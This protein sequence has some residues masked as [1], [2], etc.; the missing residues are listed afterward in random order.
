MSRKNHRK[1]YGYENIPDG[2]DIHHINLNDSI[3]DI[4][5]LIAVPKIVHR[6]IHSA[7]N[8]HLD[9]YDEDDEKFLYLWERSPILKRSNILKLI[10]IYKKNESAEKKQIEKKLREEIE[11]LYANTL[12]AYA[13]KQ[14]SKPKVKVTLSE[15]RKKEI[16]DYAINRNK[17]DIF[18]IEEKVQEFDHIF[19]Q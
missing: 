8:N 12:T 2:W 16:N 14:A 18:W 6:V 10:S 5:N 13:K 7:W 9:L 3:N 1:I 19:G 17:M 4:E 15:E 11:K